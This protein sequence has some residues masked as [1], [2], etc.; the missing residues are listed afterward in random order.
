MNRTD[1]FLEAAFAPREG[2]ASGTLDQ[3]NGILRFHPNVAQA[4]MHAAAMLGDADAVRAFLERDPATAAA[5]GGPFDCD[6]LTY[7]CFSRYLRLDRDRSE[8]FLRAARL[9]LEAGAPAN[10]GWIETIDHPNP[11]PVLESAIYGAAAVARNAELTR[12]LLQHGADPNDEETPYHVPETYDN[13]I[14]RI[15]MDSGK[16]NP[17]S[18][19]T[20]LLRKCDWHDHDGVVMLLENGADPNRLTV[21]G[22]TALHQALRR[23]N[24]LI[25]IERLLDHGADPNLTSRDGMPA[26]AIAAHRGRGDALDLFDN[27][28]LLTPLTGAFGLLA[29]CARDQKD[30]LAD[31]PEEAKLLLAHGGSLLAQFAGVGNAAGV[32][33]LLDL[34]VSPNALFREGDGYYGIARNST[35]LHVAAWRGWPAV[36]KLLID[37]GAD[38]SALDGQGRTVLQLAVKACV[39]SYWVSRRSPDSVRFLLEA[40]ASTQGIAL[41]TGY[42]E[43]DQLL[44]RG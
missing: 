33:N 30:R 2:H 31:Y 41:P 34:G 27:R 15:L 5:K 18:L 19:A 23:D 37:R 29:A 39:D 7:L 28:G 6:A 11:R 22:Y 12:L 43:I 9:L 38:V 13:T 3:A 24:R 40:G 17:Q 14:L 25:T 1:A 10:T 4:S 21:W 42:D 35:A 20:L 8:S 32:R 26:A 16:L 44:S 36:V